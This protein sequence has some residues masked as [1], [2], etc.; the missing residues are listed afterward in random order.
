MANNGNLSNV[1][2]L[3]TTKIQ[4]P[5]GIEATKREIKQGDDVV[6]SIELPPGKS[7]ADDTEK[8]PIDKLFVIDVSEP[9]GLIGGVT[10]SGAPVNSDAAATAHNDD[11]SGKG[12][13]TA[14][15]AAAPPVADKSGEN[16]GDGKLAVD[17]SVLPR[18][19]LI[20]QDF[21]IVLRAADNVFAAMNAALLKGLNLPNVT[22]S[23]ETTQR[24]VSTG[25]AGLDAFNVTVLK[26]MAPIELMFTL[27]RATP[28]LEINIVASPIEL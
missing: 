10:A 17:Q 27:K 4:I 16:A 23:E 2:S 15:V 3:I 19:S 12:E 26:V 9:I 8:S 25:I 22:I 18:Q 14:V 20:V 6:V 21:V 7:E 1:K 13:P 28:S 11:A 24:G 5:L